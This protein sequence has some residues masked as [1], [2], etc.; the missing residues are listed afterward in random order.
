MDHTRNG[1]PNGIMGAW[2]HDFTTL[3][4]MH[5][6]GVNTQQALCVCDRTDAS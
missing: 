2:C 1:V 6:S 4:D 3:G 5:R